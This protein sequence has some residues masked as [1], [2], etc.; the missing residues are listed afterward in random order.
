MKAFLISL[1]VA[2]FFTIMIGINIALEM[3]HRHAMTNLL[4]S[5]TA[6]QV[7]REGKTDKEW[8]LRKEARS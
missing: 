5:F 8:Y 3:K 2:V 4:N 6:E 7:A 1:V